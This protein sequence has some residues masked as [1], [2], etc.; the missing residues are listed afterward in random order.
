MNDFAIFLD[1]KR[2]K[3]LERAKKIKLAE[4]KVKLDMKRPKSIYS[5]KN[6]SVKHI[7]DKAAN[8]SLKLKMMIQYG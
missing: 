3:R 7:L 5:S 2:K 6:N 8:P 4:A 1:E